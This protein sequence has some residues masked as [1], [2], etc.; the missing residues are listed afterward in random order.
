MFLSQC[1]FCNI[2]SSTSFF[3]EPMHGVNL[4]RNTL[5]GGPCR[6]L[7]F[8]WVVSD[9]GELVPGGTSAHLPSFVR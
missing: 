6:C 9:Y 8:Y 7:A 5:K 4:I 3:K 2:L 1:R